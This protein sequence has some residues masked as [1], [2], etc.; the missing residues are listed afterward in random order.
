MT[1]SD[2]TLSIRGHLRVFGCEDTPLEL[3]VVPRST[4]WRALRAGPWFAGAAVAAVLVILP[5]HVLWILLAM[6]AVAL[7]VRKWTERYSLVK[8]R[9][10]CP[11]CGAEIVETGPGRFRPDGSVN[12]TACQHDSAVVL[13]RGALAA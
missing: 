7:G 1:A 12:C 8:L 6:V 9:G 3:T 11:R 13:P 4:R 5:P 2:E 10:D